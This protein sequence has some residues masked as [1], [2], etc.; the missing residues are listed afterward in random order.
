M[1]TGSMNGNCY[2]MWI[3][4]ISINLPSVAANTTG[5]VTAT[6]EGARSEDV[7]VVNKPSHETGI[8]IVNTRVSADDTIELTIM[9]TTAGAIDEVAETYNVLLVRGSLSG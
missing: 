3:K 7:V 9:N 4:Q 2:G 1:S 6:F 8:G 5:V